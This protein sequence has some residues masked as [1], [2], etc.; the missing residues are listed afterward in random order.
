MRITYYT[1]RGICRWF[2]QPKAIR[3]KR[4]KKGGGVPGGHVGKGDGSLKA[5]SIGKAFFFLETSDEEEEEGVRQFPIAVFSTMCWSM[6]RYIYMK[7]KKRVI[8]TRRIFSL[9]RDGEGIFVWCEYNISGETAGMR[10]T[11]KE[12]KHLWGL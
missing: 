11:C 3:W 12:I 8:L 1:K 2:N 5:V 9:V 7:M 10:V 6:R 4:E